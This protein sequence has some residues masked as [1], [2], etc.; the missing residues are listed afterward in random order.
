MAKNTLRLL[1][2]LLIKTNESSEEIYA[3][4]ETFDAIKVDYISIKESISTL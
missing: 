3:K 2:R 4:T 1:F